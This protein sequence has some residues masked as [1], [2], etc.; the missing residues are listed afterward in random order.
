[1]KD[2][3]MKPPSH[4]E[5]KIQFG[6]V[7]AGAQFIEW[8]IACRGRDFVINH[9]IAELQSKAQRLYLNKGIKDALTDLYKIEQA[10]E[11]IRRI[12]IDIQPQPETFVKN[13]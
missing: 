13:I 1:M 11:V 4:Y 8:M 2:D 6:G 7:Q 10:C 9:M 12:L 3:A 5:T